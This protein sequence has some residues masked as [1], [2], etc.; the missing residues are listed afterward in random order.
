[1]WMNRAQDIKDVPAVTPVEWQSDNQWNASPEGLVFQ[2]S[3]TAILEECRANP[4]GFIQ[5]PV[6]LYGAH[7]IT[8]DGKASVYGDP[9]M[10]SSNYVVSAPVLECATL[11]EASLLAWKATAYSRYYAHINFYPRFTSERPLTRLFGETF[12]IGSTIG[13]F[14]LALFSMSVLYGKESNP[15]MAALCS[16]MVLNALYLLMLISPAFELG[17]SMRMAHRIGDVSLGLGFA[18]VIICFW[19]EHLIPRWLLYTHLGL[20]ALAVPFWL[21]GTTGDTIQFGTSLPMISVLVGFAIATY[22]LIREFLKNRSLETGLTCLFSVIFVFA[23]ANDISVFTGSSSGLTFMSIGLLSAFLILLMAVNQRIAAAYTERDYLRGNLEQEVER[24]T[25]QLQQK[26][27]ELEATMNNLRQTQAELIHSAKLAS[28][29]TLSAGIA[30]E[31]NNSINFVNGALPPLEKIVAKLQAVS[32][33]DHEIAGKLL[34]AIKDGVTLTVDIV[35]SLRL[36]TGL[37][38]AKLKDVNVAEIVHSVSTILS[39]KLK[40]KFQIITNMPAELSLYCDVVGINQVLMNLITNAVDAMPEGGKITIS[41]KLEG[42]STVIEVAD[43]GQG[44]PEEIRARIFD[45]FFTTKDV[46][47]GT[48]LGLFIITN[49][50]KK[51]GGRIDVEST[52]G[53]GTTFRLTFPHLA[54]ELEGSAA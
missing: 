6:V 4:G 8:V 27:S 3:S 1:M 31:I 38:Q 17:L 14:V 49:E 50:I 28:L 45:P 15:L 37:N 2:A 30:H 21:L 32:E 43:N 51:H 35:K 9:S 23:C 39:S 22:R 18:C 33:R 5:F 34:R 44:I 54:A 11:K 24:K 13:L 40:G 46:G 10:K 7:Q 53:T 12:Y 26:T 52:V 47:Q 29:G 42:K 20:T 25:A 48:G 16:A 36:F 19:I 41:A